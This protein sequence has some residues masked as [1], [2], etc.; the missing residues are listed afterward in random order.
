MS[1]WDYR[2]DPQEGSY[3]APR[4]GCSG[5][6]SDCRGLRVGL[7]VDGGLVGLGLGLVVR[8]HH[9]Q[10]ANAGASW[11]GCHHG[12][13]YTTRTHEITHTHNTSVGGRP[14]RRGHQEKT[15]VR[16]AIFSS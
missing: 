9:G 16:Y 4:A 1:S 6:D 10:V 5:G 7:V 14:M 3:P 15:G 13:T 12:Y 2:F 8:W 11:A